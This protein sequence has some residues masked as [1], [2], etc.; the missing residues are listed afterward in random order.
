MGFVFTVNFI[1]KCFA[2]AVKDHRDMIRVRIFDQL[3]QHLGE[4][5][6]RVYRRS[7][8]T[9]HRR[10]AVIGAEKKSRS[11]DQEDMLWV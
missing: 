3:H 9:R 4:T 11:V 2:G 5:K 6:Y 7:I 10:Q 8:G 1:A